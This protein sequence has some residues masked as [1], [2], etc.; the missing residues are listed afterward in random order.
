MRRLLLLV[1]VA[2][3]ACDG[4]LPGVCKKDSDC[5]APSFCYK[6]KVCVRPDD[7][8]GDGGEPDA[9]V[10]SREDAGV[11]GGEIGR[12]AAMDGGGAE[13]E[14]GGSVDAS[15]GECTGGTSCDDGNP[16]TDDTCGAQGHCVYSPKASGQACTTDGD[17]CTEDMCDGHGV[18]TH[19]AAVTCDNPPE[20]QQLPGRCDPST[21]S[22][23]YAA[24]VANAAC[25][26]DQDACTK[27]VCDGQGVC[28]HPAVVTCE[29]PAE[30]QQLPG[31]CDPSTGS[32]VYAAK[33]ANVACG[34]DQD[35]CTKDMCDGGGACTHPAV[36]CDNPDACYQLP[37]SCNPSNGWCV[38][39]PAPA[40]APCPGD[41]CSRN[42]C[43][44]HGLCRHWYSANSPS[45]TVPTVPQPRENGQFEWLGSTVVLDTLTC[46]VW[47]SRSESDK[48]DWSSANSSKAC[49]GMFDGFDAWR[50]PTQPEL[51]SLV[52]RTTQPKIN[53]TFFP[54]TPN[55][56][57]WTSTPDP[58]NSKFA[59]F[60]DFNSGGTGWN[61][62]TLPCRVRCVR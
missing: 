51:E 6:G 50:L 17:K 47:R 13:Q 55:E 22:C 48:F 10:G 18:C 44:G 11:D 23:I 24:K 29:N 57:F 26:S 2:L 45:N 30:C 37:G 39:T 54:D 8:G 20:C 38:Y 58:W 41:A 7:A 4:P 27:D 5:E 33:A 43:D 42:V 19:P 31:H 62:M 49:A 28:T 9:D 35:A 32:C 56:A 25:G 1:V 53:S 52:D 15:I 61:D 34:A 16:C 21:G 59:T 3:V 12:D 14:D 60:V 46:L 36:V 40:D